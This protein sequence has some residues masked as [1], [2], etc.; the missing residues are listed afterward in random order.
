MSDRRDRE[1]PNRKHDLKRNLILLTIETDEGDEIEVEFPLKFEVCGTC[2][3]KG[4]HVNPSIDSHGISA[5]EFA[6]DPDFEESYFSGH[7]DLTCVEC[8]GLRVTPT[9]DRDAL[10]S[11]QKAQLAL[12]D[13]Q[14]EG[15]ASYELQCRA[16]R[17]MGY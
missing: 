12:W 11:N 2:D 17:R 7:Y 6:E 5:E 8:H 16:E 15:R 13:D 4:S 1:Y 9:V 10:S 3:G 14:E